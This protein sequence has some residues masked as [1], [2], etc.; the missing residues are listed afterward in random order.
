MGA[1]AGWLAGFVALP[2]AIYACLRVWADP[3]TFYR[4]HPMQPAALLTFVLY[5]IGAGTGLVLAS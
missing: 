3:E 1:P 5:A 4:H 2:T